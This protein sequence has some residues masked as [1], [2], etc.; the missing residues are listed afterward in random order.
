[1]IHFFL[2]KI[3]KK[4]KKRRRRRRRST[5]ALLSPITIN[6]TNKNNM[7]SYVFICPLKHTQPQPSPELSCKLVVKTRFMSN[8]IILLLL[9]I[10]LGHT[11]AYIVICKRIYRFN[12]YLY[13]IVNIKLDL[14]RCPKATHN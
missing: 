12:I 13:W 6:K 5:S 3:K 10:G 9:K 1:M 11:M 2:K 7:I 4:K 14:H 8:R